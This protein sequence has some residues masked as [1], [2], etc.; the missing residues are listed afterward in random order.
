M[1]LDLAA[2]HGLDLAGS[3]HV[4]DAEKDREAARAA[5]IGR[6]VWAKDFFGW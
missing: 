5:S 4:G 2:R 3:T 1:F 6:F